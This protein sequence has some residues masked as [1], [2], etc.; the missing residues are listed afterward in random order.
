MEY[1]SLE[2]R[3]AQGYIDMFPDFV[4][5]ERAPVSVS[6][7]ESFYDIVKGIYQLAFDEPLLFV[8]SLHE[9][10]VYPTRTK[11]TYGKPKLINDMRKFTKSVGGLMQA[12]FLLGQGDDVVLNNRQAAILSQLGINNLSSLPPAWKWM[13]TKEGANITTFSHCLFD[14]NYPY[15][16]KIYGKLLGESAFNKIVNWMIEHGYKRY[17]IYKIIASDCNLT[18]TIANPIWHKD[19][20]RGG[21]EYKIKHTG[22]SAQYDFYTAK[23]AIFGLCIPNGMKTY[24]EAFES[25]DEDLHAFVVKQTKECNL[26]KYCIQTDKT[27]KRPLA[28]TSVKYQGQEYQLCNY[29]PGYYYSWSTIDND[30]ADMIIKMLTF[31]DEFAPIV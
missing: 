22:I 1:S 27:G 2:Q 11:N 31:M 19:P 26:C 23:P 13:S 10:D 3:M 6:E 4:P 29:Y 30:L 18:L 8:P 21:F 25:M 12:M 15:T 28:N 17:N 14:D 16:T 7:Q 20:P 24:L 5:D 9:D